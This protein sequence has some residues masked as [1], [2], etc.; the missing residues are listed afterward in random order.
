MGFPCSDRGYQNE[1]A[2]TNIVGIIFLWYET[3]LSCHQSQGCPLILLKSG[4]SPTVKRALR[5]ILAEIIP[6][7]GGI[8]QNTL[9]KYS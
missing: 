4:S 8:A 3:L 5:H 7:A 1:V 6:W 9:G 2:L